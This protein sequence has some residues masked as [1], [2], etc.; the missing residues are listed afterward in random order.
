MCQYRPQYKNGML[1]HITITHHHRHQHQ[2]PTLKRIRTH[3]TLGLL[4]GAGIQQQPHAAR[5]TIASGTNQRRRSEL[6]AR[7]PKCAPTRCAANQPHSV[8]HA[9][10]SQCSSYS[11]AHATS[12]QHSHTNPNQES[13]R[14]TNVKKMLRILKTR[15]TNENKK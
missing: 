2:R 4:V 8:A 9:H 13:L 10:Q 7:A 1:P 3:L 5:V 15:K 11:M 14:V 6:R 12:R